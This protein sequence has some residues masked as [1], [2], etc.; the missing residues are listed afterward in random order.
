MARVASRLKQ[1]TGKPA[2]PSE[3]RA[4]A[5]GPSLSKSPRSTKKWDAY[6][7]LGGQSPFPH[8]PRP[9]PAEC[10]LAHLILADLHGDRDPLAGNAMAADGM[11]RPCVFPDVLDGLL[12][13]AL[14]Q[15]TNENNAIRQVSNMKHVCGDWTNYEA[16]VRNGDSALQQALQCDGLHVRKSQL[17]MEISQQVKA[18]HGTYSLS[19]LPHAEDDDAMKE[20]LSYNG[21]GPNTASCVLALTLQRSRFVVDTRIH[22]ITGYLGWRPKEATAEQARAHLECK[23]P[24][25]HNVAQVGDEA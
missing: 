14:C 16:I 13:G 23:I 6:R 1:R 10:R 20:L 8:F 4:S 25:Q 15:A 17:A 2:P 24:D 7:R 5:R 18:A 11:D 19:H 3:I 22:R 12:Y 21:V 9:P